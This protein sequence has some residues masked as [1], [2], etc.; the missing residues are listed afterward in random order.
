MIATLQL[1]RKI[2]ANIEQKVG[3]SIHDIN[4]SDPV[5]ISQIIGAKLNKTLTFSSEFPFIGRGN[6]LRENIQSSHS[7][8]REIDKILG[9]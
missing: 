4:H 3:L 7:I 8:N 9:L 5:K 2:I 1:P 6:V